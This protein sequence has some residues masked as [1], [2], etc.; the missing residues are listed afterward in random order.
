MTSASGEPQRKGA[1]VKPGL[2]LPIAVVVASW[3]LPT[4]LMGAARKTM[5]AGLDLD[6]TTR[7]IF[8]VRDFGLAIAMLSSA[9]FVIAVL[10]VL[11][12]R[13]KTN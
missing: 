3:V 1:V 12:R 8:G 13:P 11:I 2:A 6:A 9:G 4:A 7:L 10:V 5:G